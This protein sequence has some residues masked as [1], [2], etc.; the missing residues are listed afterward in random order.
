M[1]TELQKLKISI[2]C[3]GVKISQNA[4]KVLTKEGKVPLSIFEYP[5]TSG[6]SVIFPNEIYV[7]A[8]FSGKFVN[9]D[10]IIDYKDGVYKILYNNIDIPIKVLPLPDYIGE[11]SEDGFIYDNVIMTHT[12]RMRI[13]P[14][15][16]CSFDCKYCDYNRVKYE[17]IPVKKL[18]QAIDIAMKDKNLKPKH[19]LISGGTPKIEDREYLDD[20]YKEITQYLNSKDIPTDIMLAPR[21]DEGFLAKLKLWGVNGLSI[22]L[23]IFNNELAKKYNPAKHKITAENYFKFIKESVNLFGKGKIRSILIVG[24]EPIEETIKGVEEIARLGCDIVLSPFVPSENTELSKLN[25]P[26]ESTLI[27]VYERSKKITEKNGVKLGPR[28]IP[29]QHNTLAFPDGDNFYKYEL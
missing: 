2:M 28:C 27:E 11:K 19:M 29:C 26:T 7:N 25:P 10:I 8:Q 23:E 4:E 18:R 3:K 15:R 14:I 20:V 16:G 24:L 6:I 13:S 5:T 17:K 22:N 12:D 9:S 1:L 21:M